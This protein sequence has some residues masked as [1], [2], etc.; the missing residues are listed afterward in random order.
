MISSELRKCFMVKFY[1]YY[2]THIH[3]HIYLFINIKI[4]INPKWYTSIDQYPK[5]IVPLTKPV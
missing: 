5:Y 3:T 4:A 1:I 2:N